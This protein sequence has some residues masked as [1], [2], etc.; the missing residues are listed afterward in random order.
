MILSVSKR[1][2]VV[3]IREEG[4]GLGGILCFREDVPLQMQIR[5]TQ[6]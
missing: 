1:H 2:L 6:G 5:W 4:D 3:R